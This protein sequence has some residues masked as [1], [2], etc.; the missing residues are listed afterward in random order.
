MYACTYVYI[1]AVSVTKSLGECEEAAVVLDVLY[2][3][4]DAV[5][6]YIAYVQ[7]IPDR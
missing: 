5:Q 6:E 1:S 4:T 3:Y 2:L 7:P